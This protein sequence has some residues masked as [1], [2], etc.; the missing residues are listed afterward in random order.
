MVMEHATT[1]GGQPAWRVV[2]EGCDPPDL[3]LVDAVARMALA[4]NRMGWRLV[5]EPPTERLEELLGLAGLCV[6]V[7]RKPE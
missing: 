7:Q 4:A 2:V 6:E 1:S 3:A 5:L